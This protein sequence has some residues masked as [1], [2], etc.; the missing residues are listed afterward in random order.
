MFCWVI[1]QG[2]N[3]KVLNDEDCLGIASKLAAVPSILSETLA[4][5]ASQISTHMFP[6]HLLVF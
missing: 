4:L 2:K 1:G 3:N 5:K 6:G